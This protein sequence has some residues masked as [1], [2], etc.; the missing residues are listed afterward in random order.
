MLDAPIRDDEVDTFDV[1]TVDAES[2]GAM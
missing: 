1:S 2:G